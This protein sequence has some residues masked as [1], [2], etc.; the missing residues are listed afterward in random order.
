M[1]TI[2]LIAEPRTGVGSSASKATRNEGKVPCVLYGAGENVNFCV[3]AAD[4]KNLVYTPNVYKV[5]IDLEGKSYDAILQDIQFHP[6]SDAIIH[7]DFFA[8]TA[9]KPVVMEI[10]V[11][12]VGN[13]PGVRAGGKLVKKINKL[14]VRGNIANLPDYID[15]SIS[16]LEIGQSAKVKDV[17][18]EGFEIL[19]AK[20]NAVLSVKTTR[21]LMQAGADAAAAASGKK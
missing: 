8:V 21:A 6:V 10:P 7:V 18:V 12:V 9:D 19:D 2:K 5:R 14:R 3:Y 13:S 11:R 20:E 1:K 16:T 17:V 4:F 15:V